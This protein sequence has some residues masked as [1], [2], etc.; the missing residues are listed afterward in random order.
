MQFTTYAIYDNLCNATHTLIAGASGS[1]KSVILNSLICSI[2]DRGDFLFL[3]DLKRVELAR[4]K[5]LIGTLGTATEPNQVK[6]LLQHIVTLM[7][8]RYKTMKGVQSEETHIYVIIDEL[9]DLTY[10]CDKECLDL[11]VKIGRLG[12]AANI[13]LICATQDPSKK[14]LSAPLMQNFTTRI[15]L[16]CFSP[17][18]SR[19]IIGKAGAEEL[20]QYGYALMRDS[21]GVT[22][23]KVPMTS[24]SDLKTVIRAFSKPMCYVYMLL[25]WLGL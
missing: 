7:D 4:Y 9:A 20:P 5:R 22:R 1:G 8:N 13:H 2:C 18:E 21:Y 3:I 19:Q 12:R 14:T 11:I 10:S 16:R 15:A 25:A 6:P 23:V 17:I 24:E